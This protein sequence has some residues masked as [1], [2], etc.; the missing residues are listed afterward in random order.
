MQLE[1]QKHTLC[2]NSK[3]EPEFGQTFAAFPLN[4][5]KQL[6]SSNTS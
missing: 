2:D 3:R 4:E 5:T 6:F 1:H